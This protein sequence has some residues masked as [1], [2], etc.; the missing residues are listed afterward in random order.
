MLI[1][2]KYNRKF[3]VLSMT[4]I[5]SK[6]LK[7]VLTSISIVL[8]NISQDINV[9]DLGKIRVSQFHLVFSFY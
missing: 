9:N 1:F 2:Y 6:K 7:A 3:F 4:T 8:K 5:I